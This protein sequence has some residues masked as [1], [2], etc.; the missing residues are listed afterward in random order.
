MD[1]QIKEKVELSPISHSV[2][3]FQAVLQFGVGAMVDFRDQTLVTAAP[4]NWSKSIRIDDERLAKTLGVDYFK[5]PVDIAYERF[6]EWYFCPKCRK[7]L[8]LSW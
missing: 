8:L 7:K 6:P 4:E 1:N 5:F 3:A 2:R